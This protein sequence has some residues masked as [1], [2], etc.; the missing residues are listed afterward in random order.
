MKCTNPINVLLLT[1]LYLSQQYEFTFVY[2]S[3]EQNSTKPE[4][5]LIIL[6]CLHQHWWPLLVAPNVALIHSLLNL[7][8]TVDKP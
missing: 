4:P 2:C 1:S 6:S 3:G 8:E 7:H 5:A